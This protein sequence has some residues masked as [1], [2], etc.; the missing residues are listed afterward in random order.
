MDATRAFITGCFAEDRTDDL[1]GVEEMYMPMDLD[2]PPELTLGMDEEDRK[3]A[4]RVW[5]NRKAQANKLALEKVRSGVEEWEQSFQGSKGKYG[6]MK[7]KYFRVGT[8]RFSEED[9]KARKARPKPT[10]CNGALGSRPTHA[11]ELGIS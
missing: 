11:A 3:E 5:K 8:V 10:L 7:T 1:R 2:N 4:R 6:S 9:L